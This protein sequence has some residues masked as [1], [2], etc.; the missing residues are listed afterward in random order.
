MT[1]PKI[2]VQQ[3]AEAIQA[4]E[5]LAVLDPRDHNAYHAGHIFWAASLRPENAKS[6]AH[7]LVPRRS[8]RIVVTDDG[9]GEGRELYGVLKQNDGR[10]SVF[11][12]AVPKLG[13]KKAMRF[14]Q[15]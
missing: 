4:P 7:K 1:L 11:S 10:I 15:A 14:T 3:L 5:E 13:S 6:E 12:T 2:S 9:N 8:A